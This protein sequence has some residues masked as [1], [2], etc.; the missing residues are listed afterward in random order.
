M[1]P[2]IRPQTDPT[3]FSDI[4]AIVRRMWPVLLVL[5]IVY[6]LAAM[7]WFFASAIVPTWIGRYVARMLLFVGLAWVAA[8]FYVALHRFVAL[9]EVRWL[10]KL[11]VVSGEA[12]VYAAYAAM[13]TGLYFTP[14]IL[15]EILVA[16]GLPGFGALAFFVAVVTVWVLLV[17]TTTLLPM[18]ALAPETATWKAALA[19][20]RGRAWSFFIRGLVPSL[21][22]AI[23]LVFV[24][25]AAGGKTIEPVPFFVVAIAALLWLQLGLL[26]TSTRLYQRHGQSVHAGLAR[27]NRQRSG[28]I[29]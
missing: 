24:G 4:L 16:M 19:Q 2:E 5:A 7:A 26:S 27:L 11:D 9:G 22:P 18:A 14:F 6:I 10:P 20:S 17:R 13:S 29:F 21:I 12:R 28:R 3:A 23:I 1:Q 8:P 25:Q 15:R